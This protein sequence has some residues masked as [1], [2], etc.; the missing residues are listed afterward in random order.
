MAVLFA[1]ALFALSHAINDIV[2][3]GERGLTAWFSFFAIAIVWVPILL[4]SYATYRGKNWGRILIAGVT[5]FGICYL[6]WSLP[7][8]MGTKMAA[9]QLAQAALHTAATVLLFLPAG[10]Q[11]FRSLKEIKSV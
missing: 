7:P 10:H 1:I 3:I 6:P 5:V 8:V 4:I 11:W 2:R 9:L